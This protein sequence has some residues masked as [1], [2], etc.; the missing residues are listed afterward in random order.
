MTPPRE[1]VSP[2]T[3]WAK[4]AFGVYEKRIGG[5]LH[6]ITPD[7]AT[8]VVSLK[9]PDGPWCWWT[10]TETLAEA[11]AAAHGHPLSPSAEP[12]EEAVSVEPAASYPV[13][14]VVGRVSEYQSSPVNE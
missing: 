9:P 8:F 5:T 12:A 1:P 14:L 4:H 2:E 7:K 6:R 3:G 10:R 11:M 13:T